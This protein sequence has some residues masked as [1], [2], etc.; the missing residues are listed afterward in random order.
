MEKYI[1]YF[2]LR[3]PHQKAGGRR[4]SPVTSCICADCYDCPFEGCARI[5]GSIRAKATPA[6]LSFL[7]QRR[8]NGVVIEKLMTEEEATKKWRL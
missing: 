8:P 5:G 3:T 4:V 1:V 6:A 2:T 7:R